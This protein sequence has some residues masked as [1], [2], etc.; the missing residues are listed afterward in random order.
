MKDFQ[1]LFEK[2]GYFTIEASM[3]GVNHEGKI[4]CWASQKL[5]HSKPKSSYSYE[6]IKSGE[7]G[8]TE[9]LKKIFQCITEKKTIPIN[10]KF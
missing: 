6:K 5:S 3:I 8:M 4:K 1:L 2:F 10:F 7:A 9:E